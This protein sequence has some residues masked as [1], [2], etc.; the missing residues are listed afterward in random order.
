M[1]QAAKLLEVTGLSKSFGAIVVNDD[2]SFS[3]SSGDRVALIGPN[4]AGKT[5][6]VNLVA[7]DISPT[8]GKVAL[9]GADV[10]ALGVAERV[11]RGLVRTF[12]ITRLFNSL[13]VAENVALAVMQR[14]RLT[15]RMLSDLT[16]ATDIRDEWESLLVGLGIEHLAQRPIP[17]LA[18]G[19]Q[20]LVEIAIGLALKP[21]ILLL[22]EPSAG[23]PHNESHRVIE[24][25]NRLPAEIAVLMIEH[26]MDLVFRFASRV[27]VL[28]NGRVIFEGSSEQ[29]ARNEDVRKAYLGSFAHAGRVA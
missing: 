7:G 11:Q 9:L 17:Q 14:K 4:G 26:D 3:L 20:R 22:D 24:A 12:Q 29:V 21:K 15:G 25:I 19:Q 6:F 2:I 10:T 16:D 5:T 23:V 28:A 13:T 8:A 1:I 18:Y 27:I